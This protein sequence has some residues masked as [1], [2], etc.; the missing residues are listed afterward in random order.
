MRPLLE[1]A[2]VLPV[3]V[4][5]LGCSAA[6]DTSGINTD[7]QEGD[8]DADYGD[9]DGPDDGDGDGDDDS[10]TGDGD[11][12]SGDGDGDGDSG[13]GD[14]DLLDAGID[15]LDASAPLGDG[16]FSDDGGLT[17]DGGTC[18]PGSTAL[19]ACVA[20]HCCAEEEACEAGHSG[21]ASD[22]ACMFECVEHG[23][24]GNVAMCTPSCNLSN[25]LASTLA[26]CIDAH[27]SRDKL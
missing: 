25:S 10:D 1:L 19:S 14:G 4:L 2:F 8:G 20:M 16:G 27:C 17:R 5:C 13:D 6:F 18:D 24:S 3:G 7:P 15:E 23:A 21:C 11:G 26:A 22:K 12:D 9:G